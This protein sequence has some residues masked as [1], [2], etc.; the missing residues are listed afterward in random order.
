MKENVR[1]CDNTHCLQFVGQVEVGF[2]CNLEEPHP[3]PPKQR[4]YELAYHDWTQIKICGCTRF[5]MTRT[6][7]RIVDAF[8]TKCPYVEVKGETFLINM[9][10]A[11]NWKS[12]GSF[13]E[14][15]FYNTWDNKVGG[16]AAAIIECV[17]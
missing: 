11:I 1:G 6:D 15:A 2:G 12:P 16:S 14:Y 13:Q 7:N 10:E 17:P 8:T 3:N 5:N 4:R 9:K